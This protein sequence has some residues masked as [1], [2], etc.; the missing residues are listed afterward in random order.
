MPAVGRVAVFQV[1]GTHAHGFLT[2]RSP[3]EV[4]G[5]RGQFAQKDNLDGT[6]NPEDPHDADN[7]HPWSSN[8]EPP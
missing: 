4:P 8:S 7:R 1:S 3:P 5:D 6:A 2:V